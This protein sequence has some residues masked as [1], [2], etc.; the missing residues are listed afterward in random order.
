MLAS[1]FS[2]DVGLSNR[3][4]GQSRQRM[5]SDALVKLVGR[6]G[7]MRTNPMFAAGVVLI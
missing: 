5:K 7:R 1:R 6:R 3:S 2:M 4:S